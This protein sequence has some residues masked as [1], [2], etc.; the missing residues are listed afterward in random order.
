LGTSL[1]GI[2]I[3]IAM[4]AASLVG[5]AGAA[6]SWFDTRSMPRAALVGGSAAGGTLALAIAAAALFTHAG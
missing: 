4:L 5:S 2:W 3:A 6:L 1:I